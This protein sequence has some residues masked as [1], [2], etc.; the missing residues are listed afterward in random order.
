MRL[1]IATTFPKSVTDDLNARVQ[2]VKPR[3]PPASWVKPDSQHLTFAFLGERE[4]SLIDRLAPQLE[5]ALR[6]VPRFT[7][8]LNGCGLFPNARR[9]RVGWT[10]L[11]PDAPFVKIAGLIRGL[12]TN[13]MPDLK[14]YE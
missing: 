2:A 3:L 4:E 11:A 8:T 9:A 14:L 6:N 5:Q 12:L 7:A 13:N 10:G 1:F